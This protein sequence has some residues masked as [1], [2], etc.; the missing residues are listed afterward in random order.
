STARMAESLVRSLGLRTG[1]FTSPHL[2]SVRERIQI[3]GEP[4]SRE[5]FIELWADVSPILELVDAHSAER[6]GPRMSFFEVLTVLAFAAFADAPIDVCVLEVGMGGSWDATNVADADV[7]VIGPIAL[8]HET[9][10]GH[11]LE[12]IAAEKSGIIKPGSAV[13][14]ASQTES[15]MS[16]L[17][18]AFPQARIV[19]HQGVEGAGADI[20]VIERHAG[21][22]GQLVTLRTPGATYEGIFIPLFGAHQARNA[23]MALAAVEALMADGGDEG[24]LPPG[25]VE[26]A[27]A[28]VTSPGRLET[29]RRSPTIVVDAAHNPHG[30]DAV[31]EAIEESFAFSTLVGVVCVLDDKDADGIL[32]GLEPFLDEVVITKSTSPRA[33]DVN[34][35][36]RIAATYFGE[37]RV[38][39][40]PDLPSALDQAV[41]IAEADDDMTGGV[42]VIGS[43]SLVAD[44]RIMMGADRRLGERRPG[45]PPRTAPRA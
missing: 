44:V 35:L 38:T 26:Q 40:Q 1:L 17:E 21:V 20:E 34:E 4:I 23:A 3:D 33:M 22:G 12:E 7:A 27:F 19:W 6:G 13:V 30:I 28:R 29:I 8:D 39:V 32:A 24:S 9:W 36:G 45:M 10:L 43:I 31:A 2:T 16:A 25:V 14:V 37:D 42:L 18:P 41:Q 15:A 11:S 5:A